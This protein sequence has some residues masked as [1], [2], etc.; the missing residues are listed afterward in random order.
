MSVWS[1]TIIFATFML[2]ATGLQAQTATAPN[3]ANQPPQQQR[4]HE[5]NQRIDDEYRKGAFS[6]DEAQALKLDERDV[7]QQTR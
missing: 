5:A 2:A 4:V 3:P 7:K 1:A 6:R